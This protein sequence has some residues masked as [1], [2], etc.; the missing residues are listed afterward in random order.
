MTISSSEEEV[1]GLYIKGNP[2]YELIN[3]YTKQGMRVSEYRINL[4]FKNAGVGRTENTR[5]TLTDNEGYELYLD[6][7]VDLLHS[8]VYSLNICCNNSYKNNKT[9]TPTFLWDQKTVN[10]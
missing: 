5:A 1:D 6:F 4:T 2:T 8:G 9:S 3:R 7:V 10:E